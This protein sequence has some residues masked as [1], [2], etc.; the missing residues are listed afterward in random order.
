ME[1]LLCLLKHTILPNLAYTR[2]MDLLL[3][4]NSEDEM[5]LVIAETGATM[6]KT[7]LSTKIYKK[8]EEMARQNKRSVDLVLP[9]LEITKEEGDSRVQA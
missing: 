8:I 1:L 9:L 7:F 2:R 5:G 3:A 6:V 4:E